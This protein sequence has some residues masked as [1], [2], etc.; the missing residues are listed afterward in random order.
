MTLIVFY[1]P[2][3]LNWLVSVGV[4]FFA[5]LRLRR[6]LPDTF[7]PKRQALIRER[8]SLMVYTVF[9]ITTASLCVGWWRL[10]C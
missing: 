1:I 2:L 10:G 9:W 8:N 6:S 3:L 4:A 5:F 7:L